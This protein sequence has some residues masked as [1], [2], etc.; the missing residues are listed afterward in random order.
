MSTPEPTLPIEQGSS[1]W[2]WLFPTKSKKFNHS[3]YHESF[4]FGQNAV[5][6]IIS[7]SLE[8]I[9][10]YSK[11]GGAFLSADL[12]TKLAFL[13][14][15]DMFRAF[16]DIHHFQEDLYIFKEASN[17]SANTALFQQE[18]EE[19]QALEGGLATLKTLC[20]GAA[21]GGDVENVS[22]QKI[23]EI[24]DAILKTMSGPEGHLA[25]EEAILNVEFYRKYYTEAETKK[26]S[27]DIHKI[28]TEHM[29][30]GL[31][32]V[33]MIFHL[34]DGEKAFFDERLPWFLKTFLFPR[35]AGKRSADVWKFASHPRFDKNQRA[36]YEAATDD[37]VA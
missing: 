11:P 28:I 6:L 12:T 29:H 26:L 30:R 10:Q 9:V 7:R 24:C 13:K 25:R 23:H 18:T 31:S 4:V 34:E 15:V 14:Y 21:A 33:F 36:V 3:D 16:L 5:H 19:H 8:Q 35:W 27:Q 32:L 1:F 17:R 2:R 20:E 37:S 22:I